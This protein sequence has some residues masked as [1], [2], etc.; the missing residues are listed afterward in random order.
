MLR[1]FVLFAC[2][3]DCFCW[4]IALLGHLLTVARKVASQ[5]KLEEGFRLVI[6]DGVNGGNTY[7]CVSLQ[8]LK[9]SSPSYSLCVPS[10]IY[11]FNLLVR[12][13]VLSFVC[14]LSVGQAVYHLHIHLLGGRKLS[15]VNNIWAYS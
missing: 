12:M 1:L 8:T 11:T 14:Y 13:Y 3:T 7:V 15:W 10:A 2:V 5:E 4:V 9:Y 6:N